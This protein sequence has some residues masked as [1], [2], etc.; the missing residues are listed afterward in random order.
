MKDVLIFGC[1]LNSQLA[2]FYIKTDT[3]RSVKSFVVDDEHYT[4]IV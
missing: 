1:D 2:A 3:N 4:L